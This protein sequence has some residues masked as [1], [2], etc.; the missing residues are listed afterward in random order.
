MTAVNQVKHPPAGIGPAGRKVWRDTLSDY[1]LT[2]AEIS[3][4]HALCTATDQLRRIENAIKGLRS[5]VSN[6][7]QGQLVG[8]PLLGEYRAHAETVRKLAAQLALPDTTAKPAKR[9][10]NANRVSHLVAERRGA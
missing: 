1:T 4:L 2:P 5:L 8:H 7:S 10:T 6:G 3:V 9:K